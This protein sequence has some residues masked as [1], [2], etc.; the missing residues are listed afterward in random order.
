[1][2]VTLVTASFIIHNEFLLFAQ[3]RRTKAVMFFSRDNLLRLRTTRPELGGSRAHVTLSDVLELQT[4]PSTF[5][6]S[7][8][9][10]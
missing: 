5:Y 7:K 4:F 2:S 3:R 8:L 10:F 9:K 6:S 1:M